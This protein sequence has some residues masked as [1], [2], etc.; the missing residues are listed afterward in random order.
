MKKILFIVRD[1]FEVYIPITAFFVM[2]LT[3]LVQ[4]F[5]RYVLRYPLVWSMELSVIGFVW[6][7]IFGAC[8][9]MRQRT[10]IKFTMF[11]DRFAPKTA[12]ILRML[13]NLI[14]AI[15][16]FS[17]VYASWRFSFFIG[18]QKTAVARI[19]FTVMFLPFVYFLCSIIGYTAAEIIEDIKVITG[20][21]S[22]SADHSA[23]AL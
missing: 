3:I 12:A 2:A 11:Y 20:V 15:T 5:F 16:F 22:D 4:V 9:T 13:G 21:I 7:V 19:P 1:I 10:H 18:F 23:A 6:T 14:I 17:M 8:Y